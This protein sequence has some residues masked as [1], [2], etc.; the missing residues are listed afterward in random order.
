MSGKRIR[1]AL[2][3]TAAVAIATVVY[4]FVVRPWHLRWGSTNVET[5]MLLPGDDLVPHATV[6]STRAI[7]IGAPPDRV[8]PWI[9]QI[10]QGRAGFYSYDWL[11]NLFGCDIHNADRIVPAWQRIQTGD[12]VRLHPSAPALEALVVL[13]GRALVVGSPRQNAAAQQMYGSAT[14]AFVLL[15]T[16]DANSTRLV[17]RFRANPGPAVAGRLFVHALIE[18]AHFV[19][20]RKMLLG[21]RVRAEN[22]GI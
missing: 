13:P 18:P 9:A 15:S 1:W 10:G 20:E 8:W 3:L 5:A 6:V 21:I 7:T 14:W 4:W 16:V 11:E 17:V 2:R 12:N 22:A 19:M